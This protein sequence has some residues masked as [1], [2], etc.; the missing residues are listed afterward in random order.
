LDDHIE[1]QE[2][3]DHSANEERAAI[4]FRQRIE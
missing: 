4:A 1:E 3:G 2:D